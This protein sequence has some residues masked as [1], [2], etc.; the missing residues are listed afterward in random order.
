M[1]VDGGLDHALAAGLEPT[2]LVGDLDSVTDTALAWAARHTDISRHR[3]EQ[4]SDRHRTRPR[5]GF[6]VRSGAHH[7]RRWGRPARPHDRRNR[8]PRVAL[9]LTSV[10]M[11]DGWW[12]GQH[13]RVVHGPGSASLRLVPGSTSVT[14]R[15]ARP[16]PARHVVRAPSWELDRFDLEPLVGM[17]V[18]NEVPDSGDGPDRRG[19]DAF[20]RG[21]HDLRRIRPAP[22]DERRRG[23]RVMRPRAASPTFASAP[24]I[25]VGHDRHGRRAGRVGLH[26]ERRG[27]R[28]TTTGAPVTGET[29]TL[30]TYDSFPAADTS[31]NDALADF[32]AETGIAVE[33]LVAGDAGTM[34]SKASLTAGNPEGDVMWGIDNTLLSR[35]IADE[36]FEPYVASGNRRWFLEIGDEFTRAGAQRRGDAGR[37]RRRLRQLRHRVVRS[38]AISTRPRRSPT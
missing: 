37:L 20:C 33:I 15:V 3:H 24:R 35:A 14:A 12:D 30:V 16:V 1:A 21:P 10:P 19:A 32:T 5:V 22:D 25:P 9:S 7:P 2:H 28:R 4:G 34:L 36:V 13:V 26:G 38:S 18:S 11:L 27:R 8:R 23:P 29:I 6:Q 31:L 17:G